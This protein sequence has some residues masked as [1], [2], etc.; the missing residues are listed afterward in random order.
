MLVLIIEMLVFV[1]LFNAVLSPVFFYLLRIQRLAFLT[2]EA[3]VVF[4]SIL[5]KYRKKNVSVKTKPHLHN[6]LV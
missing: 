3:P 5:F 4:E 2:L 1:L 6:V